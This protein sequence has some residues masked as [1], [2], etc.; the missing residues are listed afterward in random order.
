MP[1]E[2]S[3]TWRGGRRLRGLYIAE[4]SMTSLHV[5]ESDL[6]Q[7]DRKTVQQAPGSR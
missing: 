1:G 6:Q 5:R 2:D 7:G 4:S 3:D